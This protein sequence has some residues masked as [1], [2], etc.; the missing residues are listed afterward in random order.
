M[1]DPTIAETG[2]LE[3]SPGVVSSKRVAGFVLIILGAALLGFTGLVSL[4]RTLP[5][6]NADTAL[7][8]ASTLVITGA[9][10]LGTTVLEGLGAKLGGAR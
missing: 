1:I 8:A 4:Y 2:V 10:L 3:E 5:M 9:A 6:P 7:A